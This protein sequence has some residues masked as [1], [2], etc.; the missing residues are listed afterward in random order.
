MRTFSLH[1]PHFKRSGGTGVS[2]AEHHH[3]TPTDQRLRR[4][5]GAI[6]YFVLGGILILAAAMVYGLVTASGES[7]WF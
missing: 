2:G 1:M 6:D 3:H 5:E 4:F 7:A